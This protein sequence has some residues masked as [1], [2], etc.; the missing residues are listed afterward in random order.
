MKRRFVRLAMLAI[1]GPAL[2]LAGCNFG[3]EGPTGG[4][5]ASVNGVWLQNNSNF[6]ARLVDMIPYY[7]SGAVWTLTTDY[8]TTVMEVT[9]SETD[10]CSDAAADVCMFDNDYNDNGYNGWNQCVGSTINS[11]P[12]KICT[13]QYTRVNFYY[14]PPNIR[15]ACHELAHA[16][17]LRH[18]PEDQSCVKR[19]AEGGT[20]QVLS[21]HDRD[22]LNGHY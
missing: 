11:D 3:S 19:T 5:G 22:H 4:G 7:N 12:N 17:G 2:V 20:S 14:L 8:D 9:I 13:L 1:S 6:A 15:V 18:T 21:E 10:T 16:T